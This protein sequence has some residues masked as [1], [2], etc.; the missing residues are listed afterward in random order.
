[1]RLIREMSG[2]RPGPGDCLNALNLCSFITPS[3]VDHL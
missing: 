2:M 3:D 1:L